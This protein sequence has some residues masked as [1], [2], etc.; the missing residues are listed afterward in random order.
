M[1]HRLLLIVLF[2]VGVPAV[3]TLLLLGDGQRGDVV[4]AQ[5]PG[6]LV[7]GTVRDSGG[8]TLWDARVSAWSVDREGGTREL[9]ET[10]S[11]HDGAYEILLPA[12]D[13]R[14]ELRFEASEHV[15]L[16]LPFAFVGAEAEPRAVQRVDVEMKP[17]ARLDVEITRVSGRAVGRG[18]Y[19][20]SNAPSGGLFGGIGTTSVSRSGRFEGGV[21]TLDG[22]PPSSVRLFVQLESGET[23]EATLQLATGRNRH[24]VEL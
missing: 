8:R 3:V 1:N 19:E 20:V 15:D 23:I 2:L 6:G 18:R 16:R 7:S 11:Q 17:G 4:Y 5:Q 21:L 14:Y 22:L 10:R 24:V 9:V 13:G 12:F